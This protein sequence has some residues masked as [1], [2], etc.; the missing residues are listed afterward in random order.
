MSP[1]LLRHM[2]MAKYMNRAERWLHIG[3]VSGSPVVRDLW[4]VRNSRGR[5]ERKADMH[6][7]EFWRA[8]E[9]KEAL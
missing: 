7:R 6:L 4:S 3:W 1:T 5:L 8:V 2:L 9:A